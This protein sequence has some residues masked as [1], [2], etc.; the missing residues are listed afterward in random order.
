MTAV[1]HTSLYGI[2][3]QSNSRRNKLHR[4]NQG[5]NFLGDSFSGRENVKALIQFS[6][7]SQR[8]QLKR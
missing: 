5:S 3:I 2:E 1:F 7:E 4:T 6:R 8:Q